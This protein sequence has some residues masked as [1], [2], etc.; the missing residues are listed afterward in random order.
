MVEKL[1]SR[2]VPRNVS[3]IGAS[4]SS[5]R[6]VRSAPGTFEVYNVLPLGN[7]QHPLQSFRFFCSRSHIITRG[8]KGSLVIAHWVLKSV[9]VIIRH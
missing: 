1:I 4:N 5:M 6:L 3:G 2:M 8:L 7:R 9:E